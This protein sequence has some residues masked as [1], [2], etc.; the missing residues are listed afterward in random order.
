[1]K[2]DSRDFALRALI[3]VA[4]GLAAALLALEGYGTALP[5]VAV[6][7]GLGAFVAARLQTM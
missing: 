1:M 5:A 3:L 2:F 7:G 6:G 4:G